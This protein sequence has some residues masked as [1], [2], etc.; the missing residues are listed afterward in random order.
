MSAGTVPAAALLAE[1]ATAGTH[2]GKGR[3]DHPG[4]HLLPPIELGLQSGPIDQ[5]VL[6]L[7]QLVHLSGAAQT[8]HSVL[9]GLDHQRHSRNIHLNTM[10]HGLLFQV[11][12]RHMAANAG[13]MIAMAL[14]AEVG[15]TQ[16]LQVGG[17]HF[18]LCVLSGLSLCILAV[19]LA[20]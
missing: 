5:S 1:L 7:R 13:V 12:G 2:I 4:N 15:G 14:E 11:M 16:A 20:Q 9:S 6:S 3:T 8:E 10:L 17:M 18:I 19:W